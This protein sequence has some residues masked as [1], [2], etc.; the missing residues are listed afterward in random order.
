MVIDCGGRCAGIGDCPGVAEA[1]VYGVKVP[2]A[3][4]RAG[5][6]QLRIGAGFDL[7]ERL[8]WFWPL[9]AC[10]VIAPYALCYRLTRSPWAATRSR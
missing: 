7:G 8:I 6:A 4:G 2:G 1:I 9:L 10:L 5:M 3:E